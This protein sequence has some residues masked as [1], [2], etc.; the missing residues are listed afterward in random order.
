MINNVFY[1][2]AVNIAGR[3]GGMTCKNEAEAVQAQA[4]IALAHEARTANLIALYAVLEPGV[5]RQNALI[6]IMERLYA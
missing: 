1:E 2:S 3:P 5:D 4:T 6:E